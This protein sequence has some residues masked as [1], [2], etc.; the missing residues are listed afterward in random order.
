MSTATDFKR[1]LLEIGFMHKTENIH[2]KSSYDHPRFGVV[3]FNSGKIWI[4]K[5]AKYMRDHTKQRYGDLKPIPKKVRETYYFEALSELEDYKKIKYLID[6]RVVPSG[7]DYFAISE[8][9]DYKVLMD[10]FEKF[11]KV[12][13]EEI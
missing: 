10:F 3:N 9:V 2:Y 12:H 8:K 13:T 5:V 7:E 6:L 1:F 4:N 11:M